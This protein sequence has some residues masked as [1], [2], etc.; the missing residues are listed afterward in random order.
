MLLAGDFGVEDA[1]GREC[2][3]E[4]RKFVVADCSMSPGPWTE[5]R[6][7]NQFVVINGSDHSRMK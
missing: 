6:R 5:Q 3:G 4:G 2:D 1:G 7:L